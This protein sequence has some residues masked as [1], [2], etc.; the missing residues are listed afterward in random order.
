MRRSLKKY[1]FTTLIAFSVGFIS[2][3]F[4]KKYCKS[5]DFC[6]NLYNIKKKTIYSKKILIN[7]FRVPSYVSDCD[8]KS[9]SNLPKDSLIVIGHAY[10]SH[11]GSNLRGNQKISPSVID[12]YSKNKKNIRNIIFSGDVLKVPSIKK[13]KNFYS[14][15]EE[16]TGI[17]IAPGNHDIGENEDNAFLDIFK[18]VNQQK[19]SNIIYPFYFSYQQSLFIINNSIGMSN[20]VKKI[21]SIINENKSAK[22]IFIVTHNVLP[23]I[24]K[25]HANSESKYPYIEDDKFLDLGKEIKNKNIHFIYGDGGAFPHK[26]RLVCKKIGNT[27]HVV[28]GIGDKEDDLIL[29]INKGII[30]KKNINEKD[31]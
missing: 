27:F 11:K 2:K 4:I 8:I 29:I 10:G 17:Y 28:N 25:V 6:T 15:F 18:I 14:N 5:S 21:K 9:I 30:Y 20:S 22:N 12:F 13:W 3:P 23:K 19:G 16:S 24:L 31:F 1:I 26:K 7:N